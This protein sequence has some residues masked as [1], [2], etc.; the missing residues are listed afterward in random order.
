ME[1]E[2]PIGVPGTESPIERLDAGTRRRQHRRVTRHV[3]RRGVGEVAQDREVDVRIEIAERQHF[4]VL[5][6]RRHR[7]LARQHRRHD[8][9]RP[10]LGGNRTGELETG[11]GGEAESPRR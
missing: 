6:Q 5:Q 10:R 4:E 8:D 3:A 7:R 2:E 11:T 9:H 1:E